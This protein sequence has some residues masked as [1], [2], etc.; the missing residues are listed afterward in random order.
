[1]KGA[2]KVQVIVSQ[3]SE[4][5]VSENIRMFLPFWQ[6]SITQT[7]KIIYI[8]ITIF[9]KIVHRTITFF[10]INVIFH[11]TKIRSFMS[12]IT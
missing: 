12:I 1:M 4:S 11:H 9:L 10:T 5:T 3:Y 2:R 6:F 8:N 7:N